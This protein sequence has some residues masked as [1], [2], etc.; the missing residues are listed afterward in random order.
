[1]LILHSSFLSF[2]ELM[3]CLYYEVTLD[4][5]LDVVHTSSVPP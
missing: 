5:L 4:R 2:I 3:Y 1:M